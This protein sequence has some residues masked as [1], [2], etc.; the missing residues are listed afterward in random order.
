MKPDRDQVSYFLYWIKE[1]HEIH[2]RR[3]AG[4]PFPWSKDPI[5]QRYFFCNPYRENDKTTIWYSRRIRQPLKHDA[6][7]VM[8]TV[9][10]RRFNFIPTGEILIDHNLLT[11]WDED[12][13]INVLGGLKKIFTGAFMISS[14][15][16]KPKLPEVCRMITEQWKNRE[17]T[18]ARLY[19]VKRLE[20]AWRILQSEH[21]QGLMPYEVVCDL[22]WT[23]LLGECEDIDT[24]AYF[25]PGAQRGIQRICGNNPGTS[26]NSCSQDFCQKIAKELLATTRAS[27]PEMHE[28]Q[29]F[30]MREIEHSLCEYDKYMR[31]CTGGRSKR[32]YRQRCQH[33]D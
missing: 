17:R 22:R 14:P 9:I 33:Y 26:P 2:L 24:W 11:A 7:V 25:G 31:L 29:P 20:Q 8:A 4:V 3:L 32:V 1:R 30:E 28:E 5:F 6:R 10:F 13:A 19:Q 15:N 18:Y 21:H 23:P 27:L 12:V 16:Y